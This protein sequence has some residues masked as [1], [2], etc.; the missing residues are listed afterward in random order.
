MQAGILLFMA[1]PNLAKL[2]KNARTE[3]YLLPKK[4]NGPALKHRAI[5]SANSFGP[6]EVVAN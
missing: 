5:V 1:M 6:T 3:I 2:R 4:A